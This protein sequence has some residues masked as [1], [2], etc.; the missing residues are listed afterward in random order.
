M[1]R[2]PAVIGPLELSPQIELDGKNSSNFETK[3]SDPNPE[4]GGW[5]YVTLMH[6]AK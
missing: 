1:A 2:Q 6:K 3:K 4:K 5:P